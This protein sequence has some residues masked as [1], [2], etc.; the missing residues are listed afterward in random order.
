MNNLRNR[1]KIAIDDV[2]YREDLDHCSSDS[3]LSLAESIGKE[4]D[5][6]RK[7]FISILKFNLETTKE[8]IEEESE[9]LFD[10][11]KDTP[12]SVLGSYKD[13][14]GN[15]MLKV[16]FNQRSNGIIPHDKIFSVNYIRSKYPL[17]LIDYYESILK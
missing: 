5:K 10:E 13:F 12:S 8:R 4:D 1:S 15:L 11:N 17:F 14:R 6:F 9:F 2:F 7:G 3:I 16:E